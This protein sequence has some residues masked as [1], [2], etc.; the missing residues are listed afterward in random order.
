MRNIITGKLT[1][2]DPAVARLLHSGL[3]DM[4]NE[5]PSEENRK[6]YGGPLVHIVVPQG[7]ALAGR[8]I[9]VL[10]RL[11]GWNTGGRGG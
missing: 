11:D 1:D 2:D 10:V 3:H 9:A 4:S 6:E 8:H 5:S 7:I